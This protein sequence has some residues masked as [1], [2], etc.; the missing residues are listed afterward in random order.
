MTDIIDRLNSYAECNAAMGLYTEVN[1]ID[2]A[3]DIIQNL[4]N[5]L[6]KIGYDYVEL[7]HDKVQ[8]L[9]LEH[10]EIARKAYQKSFTE[11]KITKSKLLDDNF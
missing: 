1:C 9:Y 11:E 4:R 8:Y 7:S 5:A 6:H 2:D 3:I 10:I